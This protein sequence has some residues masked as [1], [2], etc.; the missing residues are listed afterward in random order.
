[1]FHVNPV[2]NKHF[3]IAD[4][5]NTYCLP[6]SILFDILSYFDDQLLDAEIQSVFLN[7][8][9][10]ASDYQSA[11][12]LWVD[13]ESTGEI[14]MLM[15]KKLATV[16]KSYLDKFRKNDLSI[17]V[18]CQGGLLNDNRYLIHYLQK[19]TKLKLDVTDKHAYSSTLRISL[20]SYLG[21]FGEFKVDKLGCDHSIASVI[22]YSWRC[23]GLGAEQ[24]AFNLLELAM[25][26]SKHSE[27]QSLYLVQLQFMRIA[28]QYYKKAADES[29][30]V[31]DDCSELSKKLFLTKAWGNIL[32]RRINLAGEL[33]FK[34]GITM[35]TCASDIDSLYTLN[36]FA[37]YQYLSGQVNNA[38]TLEKRIK[39][40]LSENH[41]SHQVNYI[42]SINLARLY[43]Y[44]ENYP[45]AKNAYDDAFYRH[46]T[47]NSETQS[48]YANVCYGMLYEKQH[49]F[50]LALKFWLLAAI[51]WLSAK[52]PE[53]LGWRAVRAIAQPNY[54]PRTPFEV[55]TVTNSFYKKLI[56]LG[57]L[58]ALTVNTKAKLRKRITFAAGSVTSKNP[59]IFKLHNITLLAS[60]T[61]TKMLGEFNLTNSL[62]NVVTEL[63]SKLLNFNEYHFDHFFVLE[64]ATNE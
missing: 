48:I 25:A 51:H 27:I 1:M 8:L 63:L 37:L 35:Q 34:A 32:S 23:A 57:N 28:T 10:T 22:N 21:W 46:D 11:I 59:T 43:R 18:L 26:A 7:C 44:Q 30:V 49:R 24:L 38:L 31:S 45:S 4:V 54:E 33:F 50:D 41:Y 52:T 60:L 47:V 39:Q 20:E 62:A 58:N 15:A 12:D 3:I 42:N 40:V 2:S 5:S 9:P 14:A 29:R 61:A 56:V 55:S 19:I 6:Y 13:L 64:H 53:A 36:I 16:L 17:L